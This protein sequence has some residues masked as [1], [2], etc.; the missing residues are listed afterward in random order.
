MTIRRDALTIL[1]EINDGAYSNIVLSRR[2]SRIS[3]KRDR[4]LLTEIVYGVL[5]YKNRL[6]YYIIKLSN[7]PFKKIDSAVL[8]ALRM[9]IYQLL[10]LERIPDRAA[11][12]ET[13]NALKGLTHQGGI[14]FANALLRGFIRKKKHVLFPDKQSDPISYLVHYHSHPRWLVK[15]WLKQ[16]GFTRTL[17]LCSSNNQPPGLYIRMNTLKMNS[18]EFI[19]VFTNNQ[20]GVT[21]EP[22]RGSYQLKGFNSITELP[23]FND[24]GF[25]IQGPAASLAGLLL[26]VKPGMCVLDMAAGPGGKTTHLAELMNNQGSIIALD[27]YQH[28]LKL[29]KEN[30]QRMGVKIV[31][32][33]KN[34]GR[35][36]RDNK[37]FDMVLVDAP[38]SGLGLIRQKPEVKWNK[39]L[40]NINNIIRIQKDLLANA[41]RL[42]KKDGL[43]LYATCTLNKAEN[44]DVV[45]NILSSYYDKLELIDL[46]E[47]LARL[48]LAK[49]Y[50]VDSNGF[51]EMFPPES[52]TEGF[53]MAKLKKV[54]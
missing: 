35:E 50:P 47:D 8:T 36:Y 1:E 21:V 32:T 37:K 11:V 13:V 38:C 9:G 19:Q 17:K 34:D 10:F 33:V 3:D 44:Q 49:T 7:R 18:R 26:G 43:I 22:I 48:G 28:K 23:L 30:C 25:I 29:I 20:I 12:Y 45:N 39:N 15:L 46:R 24:G 41:V 16:Y 42:T 6:D 51:L 53:F 14:R 31:K 52:K 40:E 2:L 5:R 27:I 54:K 4:A